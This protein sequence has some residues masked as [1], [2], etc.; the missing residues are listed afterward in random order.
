MGKELL[1]A[2]NISRICYLF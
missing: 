1:S 2:H